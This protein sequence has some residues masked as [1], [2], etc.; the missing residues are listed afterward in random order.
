VQQLEPRDVTRELLKAVEVESGFPVHVREDVKLATVASVQLGKTLPQHTWPKEAHGRED[1]SVRLDA[2]GMS[3]RT[4]Y[5][6]PHCNHNCQR[7]A[8]QL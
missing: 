2:F 5:T 1:E 7:K 8:S 3:G 4:C 6:P